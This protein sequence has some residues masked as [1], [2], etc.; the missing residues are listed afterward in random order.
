M[1]HACNACV[2][3]PTV[4]FIERNMRAGYCLVVTVQ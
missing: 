4:Q 1:L 2:F 3:M